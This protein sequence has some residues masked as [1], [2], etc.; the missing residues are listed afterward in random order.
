MNSW[1]DAIG[2]ER[3]VQLLQQAV[4]L[5]RIAPAYLFVGASGIGRSLVAKNFTQLLF[6][7]DLPKDKQIS[8][9]QK[10]Q[11]GNHPN[12]LWVQPTYLDC[13]ELISASQ[14]AAIGLKRKALPQIRIEQIRQIHHFVSR[15]PLEASRLVVV[16]ED[17]QTM[18]EAAANALLKTLEEPGK[19]TLILIAL[20]ADSLL[21]TLVSRCQRIPFYR[22]SQLNL[23]RVLKTK[24]Y[25]EILEYPEILALA[26]GSP[27]EAIAS[28]EQ[29][30][31]ISP[32]LR[33]KLLQ[34]PNCSLDALQLAKEIERQLDI[35]TQ[36][37]LVDYL[38]YYYWQ[39]DRQ[40]NMMKQWEKTR[41]CLLSYVQP[42][43]VWECTLLMLSTVNS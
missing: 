42:R 7:A 23:Q 20:D 3:A 33:Q 34:P 12:L 28:F 1:V 29:L 19:T 16:I 39:K 32:D 22:L 37:W 17:A 2:Q 15:P 31:A 27:G 26:Q 25:E 36:L 4:A 6:C 8:V 18:T 43:L 9:R 41:Q 14:A 11:T 30:Q 40:Q 35:Q 21:S 38:Q 13:G 5:K 24:G 10:L